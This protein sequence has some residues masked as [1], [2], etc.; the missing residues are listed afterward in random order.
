MSIPIQYQSQKRQEQDARRRKVAALRLAGVRDH[1]AIG[2]Q[3]G[4]SRQTIGRDLAVLDAQWKA[5]ALADH[6][7]DKGIQY[8]RIE[9]L[10]TAL[11]PDAKRGK[12][13]A[14]DRLLGLLE[15][16]AKLLGLD[17][18]TKQE[19][20]GSTEVIIREYS[21]VDIEQI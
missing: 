10:I 19:H 21:G 12:W 3:L 18:P 2:L 11:W 9:E 15:R 17:A 14:V 16:E 13:L 20:H 8:A 7:A 5:E 4:V 1:A 6:D